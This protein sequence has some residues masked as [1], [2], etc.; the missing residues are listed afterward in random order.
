E[1]NYGTIAITFHGIL[2]DNLNIEREYP[3]KG[4]FHGLDTVKVI[5]RIKLYNSQQKEN[6][7]R[8]AIGLTIGRHNYKKE[9]LLKYIEFFKNLGIDSLRFNN[10][11][12]HGHNYP[13][14]VLNKEELE[15][16][17]NNFSFIHKN[18]N[19]NYQLGISQDFGTY[20][21]KV[22]NY[23]KNVENVKQGYNCSQ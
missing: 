19:L 18:I 9:S 23:P 20:N 2:D 1:Y 15:E 21:I 3:I 8:I 6:K 11:Y 13:E 17:Y 5:N 7:F 10:F 22:M 4:V 12:D 16:I 14:L